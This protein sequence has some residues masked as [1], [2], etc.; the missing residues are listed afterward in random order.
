M[1][2]LNGCIDD[3]RPR[4]RALQDRFG[5]RQN[6]R[7]RDG[8]IEV[9]CQIASPNAGGGLTDPA[10]TAQVVF[11]LVLQASIAA[12]PGHMQPTLPGTAACKTSS[13]C[14]AGGS[15]V[16]STLRSASKWLR[17]IRGL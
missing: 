8:T 15:T 12:Q 7:Q 14:V 9:H 4:W 6:R 10:A 17:R 11:Q 3:S 16:T 13:R 5:Q 1:L 2:V